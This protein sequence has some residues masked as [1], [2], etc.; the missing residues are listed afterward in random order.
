MYGQTLDLV[1]SNKGIKWL[2]TVT[3][4]M[5]EV[6]QMV[7]RCK[8]GTFSNAM[9]FK[10]LTRGIGMNI[11]WDHFISQYNVVQYVTV[12]VSYGQ[13][14]RHIQFI[15]EFTSV[16]SLFC[17]FATFL[18]ILLLLCSLTV[19]LYTGQNEQCY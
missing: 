5:N 18:E 9:W 3:E 12:S 13:D 4:Y 10:E 6:Q 15:R 17:R 8:L 2:V 14:Q 11:N 16:V 1:E 7:T 19:I